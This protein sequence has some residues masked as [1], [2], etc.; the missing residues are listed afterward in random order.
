[1]RIYSKSRNTRLPD[2]EYLEA[3]NA[4]CYDSF[5]SS[6]ERRAVVEISMANSRIYLTTSV[7][8]SLSELSITHSYPSY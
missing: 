1:M 5:D 4:I 2:M 3:S 8:Y 7:T 6:D